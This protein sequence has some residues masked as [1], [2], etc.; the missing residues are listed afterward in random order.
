MQEA[1]VTTQPVGAQNTCALSD[2]LPFDG[3]GAIAHQSH[4]RPITRRALMAAVNT[5]AKDI[6]LRAASVV[7]ID[8]LLS[9]LP[10]RD[11][12]TGQDNPI[13]PST[14]LTVFAANTTL[15]FR[16]K[17]ITDRQLR[18][19]LERL[20][21]IGLIQRKDSANGKRFPVLRN[22]RVIGAFGID[23][24]PLLTRS[25]ELCALAE[26]RRAEATELRGLR[27]CIQKLRQDCQRLALSA[28]VQEFLEATRNAMRRASTTVIHART[29]IAQLTAILE[30]CA[31]QPARKNSAQ[32]P[33]TVANPEP[34]T[35][36][37]PSGMSASDGQNVRHKE[38]QN[39][40]TKKTNIDTDPDFW[41]EL[42]HLHSF[43]P[44][45]PKSEHRTLQIIFEFGKMLRIT[46]DT[47]TDAI[48]RIGTRGTL[49]LQD[50][51][52]GKSDAINDFDAYAQRVVNRTK[53]VGHGQLDIQLC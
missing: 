3:M 37:E 30:E 24:S 22:G 27:A 16:A 50:Q 28:E 47:L 6:G 4:F 34:C 42:Q 12:T 19:H 21:E 38:T 9:C 32:K 18:R 43:Y 5:V 35:L 7:V 44:E 40:Y 29:L 23:L 8:A 31:S 17:G 33:E 2:P 1:N 48:A 11:R 41:S 45:P 36:T 10:C 14:L 25:E 20:E 46:Q 15:C 26:K 52:A 13:T 53:R 49:I 39:P 51:M